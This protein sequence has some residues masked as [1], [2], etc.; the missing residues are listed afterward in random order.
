MSYSLHDIEL[1]EYDGYSTREYIKVNAKQTW[2]PTNQM[3]SRQ[4]QSL[5]SI[6]SE[7][8]QI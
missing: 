2:S 1:K 3:S 5:D 4:N 7:V 8:Y 6:W